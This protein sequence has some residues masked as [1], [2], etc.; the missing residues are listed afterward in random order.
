MPGLKSNS[1]ILL[2]EENLFKEYFDDYYIILFAK[3]CPIA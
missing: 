3:K 2:E 1:F